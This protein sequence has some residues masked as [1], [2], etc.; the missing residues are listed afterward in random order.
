MSD[1]APETADTHD[2]PHTAPSPSG[3]GGGKG[4]RVAIIA[5]LLA[6]LCALGALVYWF[7]THNQEST[8]DA[9]VK[10]DI[11]Q[12]APRVT[13]TVDQVFVRDNQHVAS[14]DPL[15]TLDPADYQAALLRAEA[16][17]EAARASYDASQKQLSVTRQTGDAD[18]ERAEAALETAR[19]EADRASADARRYR[20]LYAK[21]EV[22]RQ[23]LDQADTTATSARARVREAKARLAQARAAPDQIALRE[24]QAS[25][26]KARIAQAKAEVEQA[27]LNLSYTE[28]R[29]PQAGTIAEKSVLAGSHLGAGQAALA[30]VADDPWVVANFKETQLSRMRVGQ[31]VDIEVDA[32]PDHPLHGRVESFQPGTGVT[33][34]L[35]PPQNATG[36]YVKIVQRVPVK[37][38]FDDPG[39][40]DDLGLAPGMSVVPTVDVGARPEP[41][42]R[43]RP[44]TATA[45]ASSRS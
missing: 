21:R 32:L 4:R 18:I 36:N 39:A 7:L 28:I 43:P 42:E 44:A 27:R 11:V 5:A 45:D 17:L 26:A 31:P 22:S 14:G 15:F 20:A 12:V 41:I 10:A 25:T 33:F 24:S 30:V 1:A 19:A 29:A 38:V 34:S 23:Q 9:F 6:L 3:N 40:V 35:L 8:D 16:N 2:S 37:I 13:G